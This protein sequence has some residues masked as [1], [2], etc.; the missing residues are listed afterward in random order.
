MILIDCFFHCQPLLV[1]G[2]PTTP[3][4]RTLPPTHPLYDIRAIQKSI[5]KLLK[6]TGFCRISFIFKIL[7]EQTVHFHTVAE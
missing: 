5:K 1:R 4:L 6:L 7:I 3:P 2:R